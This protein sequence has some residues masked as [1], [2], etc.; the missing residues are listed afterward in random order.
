MNGLKMRA[1]VIAVLGALGLAACGGTGS[2]ASSGA[3]ATTSG[4]ITGFGSVFVNGVEYETGGTSV[5]VDGA[6]GS[7]NELAV[8]MVVTLEG[9]VNPDGT[10]GTASHIEF[11]DE[12]Q[13]VV[14]ANN[15]AAGSTVGTLDIMGQT[16][17]VTADTVF[18]SKVAGVTSVDLIAAGNV[19]EVS[20]YSDGKGSVYA[21][22]VEVKK[23]ARDLGEEMEFKGV[24][25]ALDT[26]AQTFLIG[27][28]SVD[29]SGADVSDLPNGAPAD[30]LYVEVK[31]TGDITA[32]TLTAS[33]V[34]LEDGGVKGVQAAEGEDVELAGV[35]TGTSALPGGFELNGQPIVLTDQTEFE[36]GTLADIA[37]DAKLKVEGS[38]DADG[39]LVA[40]QVKFRESATIEMEAR[41]EAVDTA[42][43][44]VTVMGRSI[45]VNAQTLI[46]DSQDENG[47]TPVRYFSLKDL[48][49][50]D[51]VE[52]HVYEDP[53]SGALVAVRLERDD[54]HGGPEALEG[55][56]EDASVSGQMTVAGITVDITGVSGFTPAV[57]AEVEVK[58][59]YDGSG[60]LV[61]SEV[62]Q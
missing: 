10:T 41:L 40:E 45:Q 26:A 13:G 52:I 1:T 50:Q 42:A 59:T 36:H 19:V 7:E 37:L 28:L 31:S 43:G 17:N 27:T 20:G 18:E 33:K 55:T 49:P 51:W 8:G 30:G 62:S 21:T 9:T 38:V 15:I 25:Q 24:I 58:G 2:T 61:A 12:L 29:Y 23:A 5:S 34:E 35:V 48:N 39:R 22:R 47:L 57:G 4:V 11:S 53:A 14:L 56:V 46:R 32:G 16:V 6:A 54:D 44:T 60:T 3:A